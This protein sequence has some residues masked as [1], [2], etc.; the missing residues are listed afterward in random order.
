MSSKLNFKNLC[1]TIIIENTIIGGFMEI[2]SS[3]L[4]LIVMD[5][6]WEFGK[7]VDTHLKLMRGV[8]D[9][10][11]SFIVPISLPRFSSGEAKAVIEDSI[12]A[13]DVYI[14]SD[15]NNLIFK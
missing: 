15:V 3:N 4:R 10:K 14:L 9:D 6:F 8:F 2:V 1:D 11:A 7:K 12:R 5:N 13:K